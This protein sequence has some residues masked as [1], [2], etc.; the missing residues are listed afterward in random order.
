MQKIWTVDVFSG[1]FL[2]FAAVLWL[3]FLLR[4]AVGRDAYC[5][6]FILLFACWMCYIS[7]FLVANNKNMCIKSYKMV[8]C[9]LSFCAAFCSKTHCVLLHI[10]L[11]FGA[12]CLAFCCILPCVLLQNAR[13]NGAFYKTK[14]HVLC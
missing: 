6:L 11:C 3:T 14:T 9:F 5:L 1:V 13:L 10:T 2:K 8:R 7:L 12:Y 4:F